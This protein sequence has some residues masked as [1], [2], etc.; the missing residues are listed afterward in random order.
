MMAV[1]LGKFRLR[2][3]L[4]STLTISPENLT[5]ILKIIAHVAAKDKGRQD[6]AL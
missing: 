4:L 6:S 5:Q 3:T 1:E 2:T